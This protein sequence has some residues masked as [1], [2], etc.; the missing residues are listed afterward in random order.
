MLNN[1]KITNERILYE[2]THFFACAVDFEKKN[3]FLYILPSLTSRSRITTKIDN[4][5]PKSFV[6]CLSMQ[7]YGMP[8]Y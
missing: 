6:M 2:V 5:M 1:T 7:D 3:F 8:H 4:I